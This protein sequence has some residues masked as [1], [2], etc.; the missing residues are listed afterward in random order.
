M[1][2]KSIRFKVIFWYMVML[3]LTLF[4]FSAITY[5]GFYKGVY[6]DF[7][8]L[9]SSRAEGV[10]NSVNTYWQARH[11]HTPQDEAA[12]AM[13]EE[14]VMKDFIA[15]ARNWVEEKSKVP[16]LLRISVQIL[17]I[18]GKGVVASKLMP[19]I[20]S[21]DKE[22]LADILKGEDSFDTVNG[23]MINGK[24]TRF[25]VYTRPV[26][27]YGKAA[28]IVQ[29]AGPVEVI[30]VAL[31]NLRLVLFVLLPLAILLAGI[32]GFLLVR[33]TLR[34]VDKM[35]DT[36]RQ[37]TTENLKLRIHIPD[38]RDEIRRLADTFNDMIERLDRSFS[39]QQRFIQNISNELK[40]PMSILKAELDAALKENHSQEEYKTILSRSSEEIGGFSRTIENLLAITRFDDNQL[41][42]EIK[43]INLTRLVE[44]SLKDMQV[45]ADAKE[46][47]VS[48]VCS[49]TIVLDADAAQIRQLFM[50]LLDNAVKFTP[51]KGKI[52]VTLSR[53]G[54][55]ARAAV[56]DTGLGIPQNELD[57]IFD[58]F[59]QAT[60]T[61]NI[62]HSFGLGLSSAKW[63]VE[64]H[65]GTISVESQCG[66]GSTFTV[67]LPLSYPG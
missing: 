46:I 29:V 67:I 24:K 35:V 27:E 4:S 23:E 13:Q 6:G 31:A 9:L 1:F 41:V 25:R 59:Y 26:T 53:D 47:D 43:R 37:I 52:T 30:S 5:G 19:H 15:V 42:L 14:A 28:Y 40:V 11:P 10:V 54:A 34:P 36:L 62:H 63:I 17:D 49:D 64:E 8:D 61:R 2:F 48:F 51:R 18:N 44:K 45:L 65:K 58:R 39:S 22:D 66:A 21:L 20:E 38:T 60:N 12:P 7:D 3:A 55:F 56:S 57:Y 50:N 32:P 16:D 33:M